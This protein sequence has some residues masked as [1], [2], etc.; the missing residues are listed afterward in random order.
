MCIR[1]RWY[2][3]AGFTTNEGSGQDLIIAAPVAT[4]T[5]YVRFEG[6]D[7]TSATSV[8][9]TV[10]PVPVI[11]T[12]QVKT[13]CSGEA[14]NHEILLNPVNT[15]AGTLFN[16]VAPTMSDVSVQGSAGVNVVADP[17]GTTHITD[18]LENKTGGVITAIYTITPKRPTGCVG[19]PVVVVITIDPE[20]VSYTH[21]TLPT[22]PYV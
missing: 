10:N 19:I 6:C 15:P 7:T 17:A 12:G 18:A 8:I 16:W 5:Y 2:S 9:V 3:D 11:L 14:V 20:P 4:T 22:T 1:D 21:L 13:I